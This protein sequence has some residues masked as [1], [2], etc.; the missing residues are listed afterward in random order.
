MRTVDRL[1]VAL[2]LCAGCGSEPRETPAPEDDSSTAAAGRSVEAEAE[3]LYAQAARAL[4]AE[5]WT[6][7]IEHLRA[8]IAIGPYNESAHYMLGSLLVQHAPP[9][10]VVS[11]YAAAV[12]TDPKPQ[13]SH[14]FWALALEKSG[15]VEGAIVG[16]LQG[17][18]LV[19]GAGHHM[20]T[21]LLYAALAQVLRCRAWSSIRR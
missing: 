5:R 9:E 16:L 7:A 17:I 20:S 8:G 18:D 14:Y 10:E 2:V 13:S 1:L 21:G 3:A 15:D 11:H 12:A 4:Q 6:D 19:V